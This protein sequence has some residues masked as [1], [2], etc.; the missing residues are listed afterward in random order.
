[1]KV[2]ATVTLY[3][4]AVGEDRAQVMLA[5]PPDAR[6]ALAGHETRMAVG[7]VTTRLIL[8]ERP[9]RLDRVI[10][11]VFDEPALKDIVAGP[12]RLKSETVMFRNTL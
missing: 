9:K 12:V 10:C 3:I 6:V 2:A 11:S 8:P 5:V 4:P 1:M 7:E